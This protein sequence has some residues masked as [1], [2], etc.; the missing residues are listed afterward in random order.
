LAPI[1]QDYTVFVQILDQQDQIVGQI[2]A[3]PRQG[4]YPTGQWTA[5]EIVRDPY[6]VQ[7]QGELQPGEYRLQVGWYLLATLHRLP[8]LNESG[9]SIDDKVV[10]PSLLVP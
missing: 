9:A 7:L 8:V 10:V 4:T 2:D 5:G 3:W 6:V 1:D